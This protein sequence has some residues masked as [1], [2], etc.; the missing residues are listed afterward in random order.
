MTSLLNKH[1]IGHVKD[2]EVKHECIPVGGKKIKGS[3][4][5]KGGG[6]NQLVISAFTITK[7]RRTHVCRLL[8]G[9]RRGRYSC[10]RRSTSSSHRHRRSSRRK[11]RWR[12]SRAPTRSC[13]YPSCCISP[14]NNN[15][16]FLN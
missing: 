15:R 11:W 5:P 6:Y 12:Y 13:R 3:S 16:L 8:S 2:T 10:R 7:D 1:L 4:N 14:V 9:T